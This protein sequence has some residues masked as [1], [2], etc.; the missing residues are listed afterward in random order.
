M[1]LCEE[2]T[3]TRSLQ[4]HRQA[5]QPTSPADTNKEVQESFRQSRHSF[6]HSHCHHASMV[7]WIFLCYLDVRCLSQRDKWLSEATT[8]SWWEETKRTIAHHHGPI[9]FWSR[10]DLLWKRNRE[11]DAA[12]QLSSEIE[13]EQIRADFHLCMMWLDSILQVDKTWTMCASVW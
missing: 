9:G 1:D 10:R 6:H 7:S 2:E 8:R 5:L 13:K 12:L 4:L 11:H 3:S